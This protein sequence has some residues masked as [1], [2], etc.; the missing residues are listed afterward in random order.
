MKT[1]FYKFHINIIKSFSGYKSLL[2]VAAILLTG[3]IVLSGFDWFYFINTRSPL[4]Q[5]FLFP[6]VAFAPMIALFLPIV[7]L[8]IAKI[9][10][11]L[12]IKNIAFALG[13]AAIMGWLIS[14]FYKSLTGR[15]PPPL[16]NLVSADLSID[17]SNNF[18]FG[19]MREGIFWGWPSSHT[20]VAFAVAVTAFVLLYSKNKI[21]SFTA[22]ILAL[23]VGFGI[24][25]NIHWFS[26]FI[27]GAFI[28]TAI[29]LTVGKSFIRRQQ[30]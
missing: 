1:L 18:Q 16:H 7:M 4:L 20:T 24:S 8:I 27:A 29:G 17:V 28:G 5:S 6:A 2:H 10:K 25:T 19:F 21:I 3:V 23:Y 14:S 12:R 15:L 30:L 26:E 22:L 11:N 13:Q 9:K